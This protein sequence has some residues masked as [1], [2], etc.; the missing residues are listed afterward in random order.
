M[1]ALFP[2]VAGG[3]RA[4][5]PPRSP[6]R[7]RV[8]AHRPASPRTSSPRQ[9]NHV[10]QR[11]PPSSGLSVV[12]R[13]KSKASFFSSIF[14]RR[15]RRLAPKTRVVRRG[16]VRRTFES[17]SPSPRSSPRVRAPPSAS[18]PRLRRASPPATPPRT[19]AGP[20]RTHRRGF[21]RSPQRTP[22]S[23]RAIPASRML[24]A[25]ARRRSG[26]RVPFSSAVTCASSRNP[27]RFRRVR[28]Y[29]IDAVP[30]TVAS[31]LCAVGKS[32]AYGTHS[33]QVRSAAGVRDAFG[34][35]APL[36]RSSYASHRG[37]RRPT[38]PLCRRP[39]TRTR[40]VFS[41]S[42]FFEKISSSAT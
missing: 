20:R 37:T 7:R 5:S 11:L 2:R 29:T 3:S 18:P 38:P 16:V 36:E 33:R 10:L 23:V 19:R 25:D 22:P 31:A 27:A 4:D 34:V 6:A 26:G 40:S 39:R 32:D 42:S 13:A 41:K 28:V 17:P 15:A 12:R 8:S 30:R 24:F 9:R 35:C 21:P 1:T 14:F